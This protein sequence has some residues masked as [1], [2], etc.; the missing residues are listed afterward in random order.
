MML[1]KFLS[2]FSRLFAFGKRVLS[3]R[4]TSEELEQPQENACANERDENAAAKMES[5]QL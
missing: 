5:A 4:A 1:K 2:V 3:A